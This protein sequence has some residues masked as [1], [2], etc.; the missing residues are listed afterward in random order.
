MAF[1]LS[2]I[3]RG[4]EIAP[5]R[6]VVF[7][8]HGVGKTTFVAQAPSPFLIQFEQGE[9]KLDVPRHLVTGGFAEL[10]DV[11]AALYAGGHDFTSV[12]VDS[13]DWLEPVIWAEACKRHGWKDIEQPGF[14]KGYV[15]AVDVWRE[16]LDALDGL[17]A[18]GISPILIA[19]SEIKRFDS[20]ES[21]PYDRY[22][23]KLQTRASAVVQ[24]WA[25]I[26][27]F[28]NFRVYVT[29][30]DAGFGKKVARGTGAGE[31]VMYLEERPA[32]LAKNRYGLPAEL[33]LSFDALQGALFN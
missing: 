3:K 27:A 12:G 7:G 24:E 29:Q 11:F 21:E 2:K 16:V 1:D 26:V 20:P 32:Y 28:A 5:P 31:R 18:N 25:D 4:V 13:L 33:P 10:M 19:H 30:T 14:G 9:G 8:P 17:A 22:Q 6:M 23:I 15:A